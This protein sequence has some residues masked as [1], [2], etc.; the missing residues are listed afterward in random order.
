V[1]ACFASITLKDEQFADFLQRE[2]QFLS[3]TD[4]LNPPDI[5]RLEQAKSAFRSRGPFEKPLLFVKPN[6]T[7]A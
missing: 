7:D 1:G 3:A 4:E 5:F 6:C 2:P